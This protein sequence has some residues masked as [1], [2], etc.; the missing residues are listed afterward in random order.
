MKSIKQIILLAALLTSFNASAGV[1]EY[2][3]P[4]GSNIS[5]SRIGLDVPT[6][7]T[8]RFMMLSG[9][10]E[11]YGPTIPNNVLTGSIY[12]PHSFGTDFWY[13]N[14]AENINF[15]ISP[16]GLLYQDKDNYWD[17]VNGVVVDW[18]I[19]AWNTDL[20]GITFNSS[21]GGTWQLALVPEP[22]AYAMLGLGLGLVGFAAA[23]RRKDL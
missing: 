9:A 21:I 2:I 1:Y 20:Y 18:G 6:Y 22:S 11:L 14:P 3:A 23:R 10:H 13:I 15:N 5:I 17:F 8:G 16:H 4:E 12:Y 7:F 19:S